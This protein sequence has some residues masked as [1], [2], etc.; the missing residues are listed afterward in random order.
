MEN[1]QSESLFKKIK[2]VDIMEMS[3][4]SNTIYK[5]LF[6]GIQDVKPLLQKWYFYKKANHLLYLAVSLST[7]L[8]FPCHIYA[9][10]K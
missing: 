8:N 3:I 2:A 10:N 5:F 1:W 4:V 7:P 6:N 9:N